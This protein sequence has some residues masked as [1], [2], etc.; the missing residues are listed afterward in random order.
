MKIEIWSDIACPWCW[1]G[2]RRFE[3]ALETSGEKVE[4][5]WRAFELDPAAPKEREGSQASHLA[6]K[7]GRSMAQAEQMLQ[8]MTDTGKKD[9]LD[10]R[11]DTVRGG[12]TFDGHR[13]IHFAGERGKQDAVK[14]RLMKA[15]M[16]EGASMSDH[17]TLVRLGSECGLDAE[18]I[19]AML[20]SDACS[21]EVR[22]DESMAREL[23]IS[24][25]PFFVLDG[26]YAISGA[27]PAEVFVKALEMAA[28]EAKKPQVVAEGDACG[29]DGC[30]V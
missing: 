9:G 27:Q 16:S 7:Y 29:P 20:A 11:F 18:E 2:K 25:V 24:G 14:E 6:Q 8:Q 21:K 13:L 4:V 3:K 12:N 10:F 15:Y 23:G 22:E 17:E 26:K 19:R 28:K 30:A 5:T 1:V